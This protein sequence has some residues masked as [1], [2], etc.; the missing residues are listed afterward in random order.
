VE[1]AQP[2]Q[3]EL[4]VWVVHADEELVWVVFEDEALEVDYIIVYHSQVGLDA[5]SVVV[6]G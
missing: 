4:P 1:G 3:R 6:L 2:I 5:N